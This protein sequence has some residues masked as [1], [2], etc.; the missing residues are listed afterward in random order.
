MAETTTSCPICVIANTI[1]HGDMGAGISDRGPIVSKYIFTSKAHLHDEY[2]ICLESP[3][4]IHAG[5][6]DHLLATD[7]Q[8]CRL[9]TLSAH[10]KLL[11][12]IIHMEEPIQTNPCTSM[13]LVLNY[14][15]C[16]H[17]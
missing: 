2:G 16:F 12:D 17:Y 4:T 5:N 1:C 14:R 9:E 13:L 10:D 11:L 6:V 7:R 3:V 8:Q 15:L